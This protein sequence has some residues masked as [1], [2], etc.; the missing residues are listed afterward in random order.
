MFTAKFWLDFPCSSVARLQGQ[1]LE[2]KEALLPN[3]MVTLQAESKAS[4]VPIPNVLYCSKRQYSLLFPKENASYWPNPTS[5]CIIQEVC[6]KYMVWQPRASSFKNVRIDTKLRTRRKQFDCFGKGPDSQNTLK[7]SLDWRLKIQDFRR[8]YF[9]D[10]IRFFN[11]NRTLN[12]C[13]SCI[14]RLG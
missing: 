6:E 9:L 13:C 5:Y 8:K 2:S 14:A 12:P 7:T 10:P 4:S 3:A 1:P 11:L